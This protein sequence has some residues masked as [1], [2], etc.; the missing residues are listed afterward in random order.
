VVDSLAFEAEED[1][2]AAALVLLESELAAGLPFAVLASEPAD[3]S[4]LGLFEPYRSLYQPPPLRMKPAPPV[5]S[6]SALSLPQLAQV[7]SALSLI[8]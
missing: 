8:D 4:P 3:D 5:M 6:R 2:A 1:A 7:V